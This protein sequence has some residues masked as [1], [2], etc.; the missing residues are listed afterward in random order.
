MSGA[1]SARLLEESSACTP[2]GVHTSIRIIDPPLCVR[3]AE[4]AYIED[5][6]LPGG[7]FFTNTQFEYD[8]RTG[9]IRDQLACA[10]RTSSCAAR[11]RLS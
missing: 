11:S 6:E 5:V 8:A 3:R 2:G 4:G 10:C 7:C 1:G 9:P